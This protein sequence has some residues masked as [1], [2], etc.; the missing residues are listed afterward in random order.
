MTVSTSKAVLSDTGY[1]HI[2]SMSHDGRGVTHVNGKAV[3]IDDGLPDERVLLEYQRRHRRFD[4]A[5]VATI[6]QASPHRV[7]PQCPHFG[8]CG[9][10]SLQHMEPGAQIQAKQ[11]ILLDNLRHIGKVEP[12]T[13]L[14][15]LTGTHW[16]YR[17]KARISVKYVEKKQ[18]VLV[19]FREKR[20]SYIA[21]INE[22]KVLHPSVGTRLMALRGLIIGLKAYRNIPQIE[23][24]VGDEATGL[25]F[26]HLVPLEVEDIQ[27]F[28]EFG[29]QHHL[30]IYLQPAGPD[31]VTLLWPQGATLSYS[32][33]QHDI[34]FIFQPTGF[35]QV[36][37]EINHKM[38]DQALAM[39]ELDRDDRVLD[40]FCGL[41]NFSLPIARRVAKVVGIEGDAGLIEQAQ[42]NAACN[43][44]DN[45]E[46]I[47]A[48]LTAPLSHPAL[49]QKF[50]KVLLD[51][52]RTGAKEVIPQ[53]AA[54]GVSRIVYISCN[55]ATLARDAGELVHRHG[56]TL[57]RAGV[58]DM[59]PHT[60]HVETIALFERNVV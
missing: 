38:I 7:S 13:L 52:P 23:V 21:D 9:G 41:G 43:N 24:A 48:D 37:S 44:I 4:E 29:E 56:Y 50:D 26:R 51:P 8:V 11:Q 30:Q 5:R 1:V 58:M 15:P 60:T 10:C 36:N 34:K 35:V 28:R 12:Q 32:L 55:P 59:F 14:A 3:F 42:S 39:L 49:S 45:V 40:L 6:I 2:E 47:T 16:G 19:G 57:T 22:C 33:P 46:F 17:R 53:I 25:V 18:S 27:K 31:S 54:L 20:S